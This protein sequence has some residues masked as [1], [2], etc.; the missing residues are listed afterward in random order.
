MT[1]AGISIEDPNHPLVQ[2]DTAIEEIVDNVV[3]KSS[4]LSVRK[5]FVGVIDRL[6]LYIRSKVLALVI[7]IFDIVVNNLF[8]RLHSWEKKKQWKMQRRY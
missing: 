8:G 2:L 6:I 4:Q 1:A 7:V 3:M 5:I